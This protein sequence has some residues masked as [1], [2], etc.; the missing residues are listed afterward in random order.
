M[1]V[2]FTAMK[3]FIENKIE[4]LSEE[5]S[6][7]GVYFFAFGEPS[8]RK[9]HSIAKLNVFQMPLMVKSIIDSISWFIFLNM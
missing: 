5:K 3:L 2:N 1:K 4:I 9:K 7:F 6:I 8:I